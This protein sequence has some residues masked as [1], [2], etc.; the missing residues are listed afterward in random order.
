MHISYSYS[1]SYGKLITYCIWVVLLA[2]LF[3]VPI[4]DG[5]SATNVALCLA[6]VILYI[7][8][9]VF[10]L[11]LVP[12]K[13]LITGAFILL[14]LTIIS[15]LGLRSTLNANN[16]ADLF[17]LIVSVTWIALGVMWFFGYWAS[18]Y[19]F[20]KTS[21]RLALMFGVAISMYVIVILVL[22][23][24]NGLTDYR[25]KV[26]SFLPTGING[27]LF[28]MTWLQVFLVR[29]I[30]DKNEK[31]TNK[32]A[33]LFVMMAT[34]L[35][36]F[37]LGSRQF[38]VAA[39]GLIAISWFMI[40]RLR[41]KIK[42]AVMAAVA[43]MTVSMVFLCS[44]FA[45]NTVSQRID[46]TVRQ[47]ETGSRRFAVMGESVAIIGENGLIGGG[48]GYAKKIVGQPI[49]N[50]Y[51][52][53]MVDYGI[54]AFIILIICIAICLA[55]SG[56]MLYKIKARKYAPVELVLWFVMLL[57][58]FWY[59]IFNEVIREYSLW[60][61]SGALFGR[62]DIIRKKIQNGFGGN[63]QYSASFL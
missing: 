47:L 8:L 59:A 11:A 19:I 24:K 20:N 34:F 16:P 9:F 12:G 6:I 3:N 25:Y 4:Y 15:F 60:V 7:L 30:F 22:A 41:G 56:I 52:E 38:I 44:D 45:K 53:F 36:G 50:F 58:F 2:F 48:V 1:Y 27:F 13:E 46:Q 23:A 40:G 28:S 32:R 42:F 29:I 14:L 43:V 18:D 57:S 39:L 31:V 61:F 26:N 21:Q 10:K 17:G 49:E 5:V 51:L 37:I 55:K 35:F 54:L 62:L 63:V 33:A